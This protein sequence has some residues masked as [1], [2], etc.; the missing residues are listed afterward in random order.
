MSEKEAVAPVHHRKNQ[1]FGLTG[2]NLIRAIT[3]TA[4][5]S[6]TLFGYDQVRSFC[7]LLWFAFMWG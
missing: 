1:F 5:I 6:Y 2:D 4:T 3:M 7:R